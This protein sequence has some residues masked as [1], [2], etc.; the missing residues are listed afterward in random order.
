MLLRCGA[1]VV[2]QH[3]A[4]T[5]ATLDV[6]LVSADILARLDDP[7]IKALMVSFSMIMFQELP[8]SIA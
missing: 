3:A 1:I 6:T 7:V 4:E 2:S 8:N 5:F